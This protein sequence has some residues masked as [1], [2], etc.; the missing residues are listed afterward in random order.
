MY[1]NFSKKE[2]EFIKNLCIQ[3]NASWVGTDPLS[4]KIIKK[5][6]AVEKAN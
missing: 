5:I 1:I 4:E 6:S 2:V 3:Q